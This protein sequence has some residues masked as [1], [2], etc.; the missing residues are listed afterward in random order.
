MGDN[1]ARIDNFT[2]T[3]FAFAV[4]QLVIGGAR[5]PENFEALVGSW[6]DIPARR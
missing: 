5:V 3:A 6:D 2:D 1:T 4:S